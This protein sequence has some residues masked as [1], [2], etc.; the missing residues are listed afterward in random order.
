MILIYGNEDYLI[1][2]QLEKKLLPLRDQ[3]IL[4]ELNWTSLDVA[5]LEWDRFVLEVEQFPLGSQF[6]VVILKKLEN[7]N[8]EFGGSLVRWL[9]KNASETQGEDHFTKLF[10]TASDLDFRKKWVKEL[11]TLCES[12]EC[13]KPFANQ[14][15]RWVAELCSARG[16][17]VSSEAAEMLIER[18]NGEM[19]SIENIVDQLAL[20]LMPKRDHIELEDVL[21]MTSPGFSR[22]VFEIVGAVSAKKHQ[23]A[24]KSYLSQGESSST[25]DLG[26]LALLGREF[27]ALK[28]MKL[29]LVK[30]IPKAE[31]PKELGMPAFAVDQVRRNVDLWS[32]EEIDNRLLQLS[33]MDLAIKTGSKTSGLKLELFVST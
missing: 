25:G 17:G 22:S 11:S 24:Q 23:L 7:A 30:Q 16:L 10:A 28:K 21:Q 14:W 32:P 33:D 13:K 26:L 29:L 8:E 31:W 6:R 20:R 12:Y 3:V 27:R 5:G 2:R 15:P 19:R 18:S 1:D 9:K 4:P